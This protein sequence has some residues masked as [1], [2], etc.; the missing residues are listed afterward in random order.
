MFIKKAFA[1]RVNGVSEFVTWVAEVKKNF[2]Y[3]KDDAL[4][5]W[6]RGQHGDWPL[7]PKLYRPEYGGHAR[8][9]RDLVEEEIREQFI[10]EAHIFCE[11]IPAGDDDWEWY[12]LM[13]HFGAPTRLLDWTEGALL[14]LYF[15]IRGNPGYYNSVVWA[16][17]V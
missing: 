4:G 9:R 5:P 12:F 16:L 15:S 3:E 1:K 10:S 7:Y 14:G 2:K 6:F 11:T 8:V 13:Q 17:V